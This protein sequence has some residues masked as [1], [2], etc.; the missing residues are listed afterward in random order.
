MKEQFKNFNSN[1]T[2]DY[3]IIEYHYVET[4][5]GTTKTMQIQVK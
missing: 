2:V 1:S 4:S 3:S 5:T